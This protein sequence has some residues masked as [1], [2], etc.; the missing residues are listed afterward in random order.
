MSGSCRTNQPAAPSPAKSAASTQNGT[1]GRCFFAVSRSNSRISRCALSRS[2]S[3]S[4]PEN[5]FGQSGRAGEAA[6]ASSSGRESREAASCESVSSASSRGSLAHTA[7]AAFS[8]F[9]ACI[10]ARFASK[11]CAFFRWASTARSARRSASQAACCVCSVCSCARSAR[12]FS[13]SLASAVNAPSTVASSRSASGMRP[14]LLCRTRFCHAS[15][16][17]SAAAKLIAS[18]PVV[19]SADKRAS[20]S[21]S[22]VSPSP[23]WRTKALRWYTLFGTP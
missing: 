10:A 8:R 9:A 6:A 21:A 1:D 4:T 18:S 14:V 16:R 19:T 20:R 3:S 22:A 7:D 17:L 23:A 5:A 13:C 12:F 15:S 2:R 11:S